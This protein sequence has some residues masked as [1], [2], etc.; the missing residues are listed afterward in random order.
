MGFD[1]VSKGS[2][3]R[4]QI[5]HNTVAVEP[6]KAQQIRIIISADIAAR[7]GAAAF[8]DV[9]V[10]THEDFGSL[11][12]VPCETPSENSYRLARMKA[13]H[14]MVALSFSRCGFPKENIPKTCLHAPFI[15]SETAVTVH[16]PELFRRKSPPVKAVA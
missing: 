11:R 9:Y 3:N 6:S 4:R 13:G 2:F 16:L 8:C 10:G 14:L 12:I 1:L 15:A 7:F 5:L